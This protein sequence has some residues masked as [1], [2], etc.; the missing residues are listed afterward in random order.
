M[1]MSF[2]LQALCARYISESKGKLQSKV[3]EV[4][5]VIDK[6]VAHMKLEAL[7][8]RIDKLTQEQEEY[9]RG[10]GE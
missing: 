6:Q 7:G 10:W 9:L 3:Y 2:A 4:P 8:I 5:E 1:D